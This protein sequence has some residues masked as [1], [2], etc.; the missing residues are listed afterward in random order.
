MKDKLLKEFAT[1]F[2]DTEGVKVYF[3]PGRVNLIGEHIDYSGGRVLPCTLTLGTYGVARRRRD[4]KICFYSCNVSNCGILECKVNEY[5]VKHEKDWTNYPKGVMWAFAEKGMKLSCGMDL[6]I[7]GDLPSGAGLSSSASLEVLTAFILRDLYGFTVS[8]EEIALLGQRAENKFCGVNCGI[9]D[10][11]AVATGKKDHAIYLNTSNLEYEYVP[12]VLSG[13][14]LVIANSNKKHSLGDSKYNERRQECETALKELQQV[15][16]IEHLCDL[17]EDMFQTYQSA[18]KDETR[19]RRVRHA[20][21]ENQRVKQA[22]EALKAGNLEQFGQ[23]LNESHH[24]MS[25]DYEVTGDEMDALAEAA[26]QQEGVIGSR[27]TGGGFGGSTIS[28]VK[29]EFIDSFIKETGKQ[30]TEKTGLIA[31]FYIVEIGSGPM[32]Q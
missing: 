31:D 15:I 28:I 20:V 14:K 25:E 6:M 24:S 9:M 30:Y 10:Q 13:A 17:D 2:G 23:Y 8:D 12:V 26:W 29:D 1:V 22:T 27:M 16:G 5:Q 7:Y 18:I 4:D 32:V 19:R 3:A 11:F 21:Y